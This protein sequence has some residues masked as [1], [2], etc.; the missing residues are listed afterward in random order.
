M[1]AIFEGNWGRLGGERIILLKPYG[2]WGMDNVWPAY[3]DY[4]CILRD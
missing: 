4:Y 2:D 1:R 3:R